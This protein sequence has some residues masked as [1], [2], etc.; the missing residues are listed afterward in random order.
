MVGVRVLDAASISEFNELVR[1]RFNKV[2]LSVTKCREGLLVVF[3]CK[4]CD[5]RLTLGVLSS[6]RMGM[7]SPNKLERAG[8]VRILT[9]LR[10][11]AVTKE[12]L[13]SHLD[14]LGCFL[15]SAPI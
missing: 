3:C 8:V 1:L 10:N 9:S 2:I 13:P 11:S 15:G 14:M 12:I 7:L 5:I 6:Q 4:S